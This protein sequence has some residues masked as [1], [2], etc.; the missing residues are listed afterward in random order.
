[1]RSYVANH[2]SLAPKCILMAA[3]LHAG[4]DTA[5]EDGPPGSLVAIAEVSFTAETRSS[6]VT[7]DP[8][9]A[10]AYLCNMAVVPD[11][12]RRGIARELLRCVARGWMHGM[13]MCC[14]HVMWAC[15]VLRPRMT[16]SVWA[17]LG[18]PM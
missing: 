7:L 13:C 18:L 4:T 15:A 17:V 12:R 6:Y 16:L 9:P 8:P 2:V 5:Q 1:M 3:V 10:S 11:M 14:V